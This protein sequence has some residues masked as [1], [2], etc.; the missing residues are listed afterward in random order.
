MSSLARLDLHEVDVANTY[1]NSLSLLTRL[2]SLEIIEKKIAESGRKLNFR[3][4]GITTE[5]VDNLVD[6]VAFIR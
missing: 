2:R 3:K 1:I 5:D 6:F 4:P